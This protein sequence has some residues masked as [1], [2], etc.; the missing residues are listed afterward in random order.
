MIFSQIDTFFDGTTLEWLDRESL[1]YTDN[2][3]VVII[4][5]DYGA[6]LFK[7]KRKLKTESLSE[8]NEIPENGTK[9]IGEYKKKEIILKVQLYYALQKV[10]CE[11]D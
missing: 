6:G 3:Y 8:W 1:K 7:V 2:G 10:K 9:E 5:V 11:I 4:W